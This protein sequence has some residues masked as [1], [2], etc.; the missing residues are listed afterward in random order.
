[1]ERWMENIFHVNKSEKK[2]RVAI[3]ASDKTDYKRKTVTRDKKGHLCT[4]IKK[5]MQ[6]EDKTIV[7]KYI[8]IHTHTHT[9]LRQV[10]TNI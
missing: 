5:S 10:H 9:H 8:Y 4:M 3:L 6:Q 1:M 7:K 2:A